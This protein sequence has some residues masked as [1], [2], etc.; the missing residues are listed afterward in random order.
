MTVPEHP[1]DQNGDVVGVGM[2]TGEELQGSAEDGA[3]RLRTDECRPVL[4]IARWED[5]MRGAD[6]N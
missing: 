1:H 5:T 6:D 3:P 4:Q 2:T